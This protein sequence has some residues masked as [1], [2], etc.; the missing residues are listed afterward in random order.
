M[1]LEQ[2]EIESAMRILKTDFPKLDRWD[3]RNLIDEYYPGFTAW[4]MKSIG[5]GDYADKNFFITF[6]RWEHTWSGQL[7]IGKH[8]YFWDSADV[9]DAHLVNS[10]NCVTLEEAIASLKQNVK[11]VLEIFM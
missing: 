11:L 7:T 2:S 3:Y 5:K 8:C 6:E 9:G 4:G 10:K 1:L